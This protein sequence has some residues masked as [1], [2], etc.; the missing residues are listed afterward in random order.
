MTDLEYLRTFGCEAAGCTHPDYTRRGRHTPRCV[1][2]EFDQALDEVKD[3]RQRLLRI[4]QAE[5]LHGAQG[6]AE[7]WAE[8]E[9]GP[10]H[11]YR[12]DP[13]SLNSTGGRPA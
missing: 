13:D 11:C 10:D 2:S 7:R 5:D 4:A 6:F 1:Q 9:Y 3:L 8:R 12:L